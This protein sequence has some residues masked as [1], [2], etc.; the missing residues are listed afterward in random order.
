MRSIENPDNFRK[1]VRKQLRKF[2]IKDSHAINLEKSILNYAILKSSERNVVKKWENP[3]FIQIY[4]DRF[5]TVWLNIKNTKLLEKIKSKEIKPHEIGKMTHQEMQ[6]EKWKLLIQK[7]KDR[8]ENRYTSKLEANTDN[9]KCRKC[10]SKECSYY[11]L[12]TR[13]AD[14]PMTTYVTCIK[15]GNRWKC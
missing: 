13:S 5:I 6:P 10:G 1:N 3:Y 2:M 12:Q 11:Q 14:E 15:C 7:K 9:Y 8:D 4:I